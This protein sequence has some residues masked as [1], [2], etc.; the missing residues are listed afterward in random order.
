MNV[1][2]SYLIRD[3]PKVTQLTKFQGRAIGRLGKSFRS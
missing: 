3:V 1:L 2:K